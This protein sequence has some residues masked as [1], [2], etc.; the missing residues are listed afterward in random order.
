M[1][2]PCTFRLPNPSRKYLIRDHQ[3]SECTFGT[4]DSGPNC[5]DRNTC[6]ACT[7]RLCCCLEYWQPWQP[8]LTALSSRRCDTTT[9]TPF[10]QEVH[11][12]VLE[13]VSHRESR[14]VKTSRD[15]VFVGHQGLSPSTNQKPYFPCEWGHQP[16][17]NK[18]PGRKTHWSRR[19]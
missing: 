18:N 14:L 12:A 3:T 17:P 9:M 4:L 6:A 11:K 13:S 2:Q 1:R 16:L 8:S 5:F 10:L 15:V 7:I 19:F